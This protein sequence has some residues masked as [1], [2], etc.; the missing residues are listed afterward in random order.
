MDA[1]LVSGESVPQSVE[2]GAKVFAG[3]VNL[4]A[5]LRVRVT[6]AGEHTLLSEIVRLVEAA[7]RGRSRFVALADRVARA[8]APVVHATALLTF[9]GWMVLG[10]LR[11]GPRAARGD[12]RA[13]HHLPL[14]AGAR[15]ARGP[16]RGEHAAAAQRH[17][18]A[19]AD[20]ARAHRPNR[21]CRARQDRNPDARPAGAG[22]GRRRRRGAAG[23]RH[24]RRQLA[25]PAGAGAGPRGARHGPRRRCRRAFR[26][27]PDGGREPPRIGTLLRRCR[28]AR[29]RSFRTLVRRAPAGR[30]GASP[31]PTDCGRTRRLRSRPCSSAA[32]R[33]S[34]CRAIALPRSPARPPRPA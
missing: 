15:R 19:L 29:R 13:D 21:P 31:S 12:G 4:G 14:R 16:G 9:L 26:P 8:Y 30:R 2:R 24:H 11:L 7:E 34:C 5:P 17:P 3:M 18:A 32:S 25:P 22:R 20:G 28:S 1:A 23:R 33:S 27:G 10:G 6:A